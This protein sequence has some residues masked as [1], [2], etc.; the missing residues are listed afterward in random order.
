MLEQ[1]L[2][3][4]VFF[5]CQKFFSALLQKFLETLALAAPQYLR[6]LKMIVWDSAGALKYLG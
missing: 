6:V 1:M 5:S 3:P 4:G 2:E